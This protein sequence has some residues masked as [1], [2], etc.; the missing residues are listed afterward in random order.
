MLCV[1]SIRIQQ[2]TETV[3]C[4]RFTQLVPHTIRV[5]K[6]STPRH[7]R[8]P[9]RGVHLAGTASMCV[10]TETCFHRA[11]FFFLISSFVVSILFLILRAR[12]RAQAIPLRNIGH[13]PKRVCRAYVCRADCMGI[14]LACSMKKSYFD[15][16]RVRSVCTRIE[17][18]KD[19]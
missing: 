18:G 4:V 19:T 14:L 16:L 1:S 2:C 8:H 7:R 6:T 11:L 17:I 10:R 12:T 9:H 13:R 3:V 5:P 15:I